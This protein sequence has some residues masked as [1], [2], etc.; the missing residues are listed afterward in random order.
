MAL[1]EV[2][3][4][5]KS[6]G[7]LSALRGVS[8]S[9]EKGEVLGL[10]GP[11]GSGKSTLFNMLTKI[12]TGPD[13]GEVRL[14]GQS[15][16][17]MRA[18][19]IA[20][21]GLV[22]IFQTETDFGDL[23]VIE[24]VL[25]SMP[26][27]T[28]PGRRAGRGVA[29]ALLAEFDLADHADQPSGEIGVFNRKKLMIVTALARQPKVL[30]LDEPAA[31]LSKPEVKAMIALIKQI[32]AKGIAVVVIEHV[33]SLLLALSEQLIVLN[34]GEVLARGNPRDV[35]RDPA[36]VEAYLGSAADDV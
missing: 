12:P 5:T 15:L 28:Q 6:F 31:G 3:G 33:I 8:F 14:D 13:A 23:S 30:L 7:A 17:R 20:R 26:P 35:V 18:H 19:Q 11:N 16:K 27:E 34:Y 24:N 36:V 2:D 25:V 21:A 32:N 1:L 22:R 29:M 10:A 4:L 9:I